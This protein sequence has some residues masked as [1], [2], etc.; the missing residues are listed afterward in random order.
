MKSK[1]IK[2]II[3]LIKDNSQVYN[4]L[5][6]IDN[7]ISR[8]EINLNKLIEVID[9]YKDF[10]IKNIP[11]RKII[12]NHYGNPYITA[13]LCLEAICNN[14]DLIIGINDL[15]YSVNKAIVK[16]INDV[17]KD[18]KIDIKLELMNELVL[19]GYSNIYKVVCLGDSNTYM[20]FRKNNNFRVEYVPLYD[21]NIYYDS[22]DF[23]ELANSIGDYA[24]QNFGEIE[25]YDESQDFDDVIQCINDDFE[26]YC[27]VILSKDK[28]KQNRFKNEINSKIICI[29]ENPF[30]KFKLEVPSKVWE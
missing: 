2:N 22:Y 4:K 20:D 26:K 13:K 21:I 27:S 30:R 18:Y 25:V 29:N 10:E 7:D 12:V 11:K 5:I 24:I 3:E 28:D 17:A 1:M 9:D 6:K 8:V 16:T 19:D 14:T 15:C 23:E